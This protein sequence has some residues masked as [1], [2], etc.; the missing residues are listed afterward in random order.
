VEA[1][2]IEPA[3]APK[4]STNTPM[5]SDDCPSCRA[6]RALHPGS[7]E[8]PPLSRDDVRLQ[9]IIDAW[10]ELPEHMKLAMEALCAADKSIGG[11]A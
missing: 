3:I 8:C 6:A 4:A 1:A 5:S 7:S 9:R 10:G 11:K 2:G